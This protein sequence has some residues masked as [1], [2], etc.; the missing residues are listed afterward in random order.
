M[1]TELTAHYRRVKNCRGI[2]LL[3]APYF[4]Y[5]ATRLTLVEDPTCK[6]FWTDGTRIGYSPTYLDSVTDAE[7]RGV[8]VHEVLH[9]ALGHPWRRG[10]RDPDLW[11]VAADYALNPLVLAGGFTLPAGALLDDAYSGHNAE[12]IYDRLQAKQKKQ[13][14]PAG[15]GQGQPQPGQG[16][17]QPGQPGDQGKPDQ[18]GKP[19][20]G[21]AQKGSQPG[22]AAPGQANATPGVGEVRDAPPPAPATDQ[23]D[24]VAP[25][26]TESDWAEAVQI[27]QQVAKQQGKLPGGLRRE[28]KR[29]LR[30]PVDWRAVLLRWLQEQTAADYSWNHPNRRY[31]RFGYVLPSLHSVDC[32]RLAVFIDTSGSVDDVVLGQFGEQLSAVAAA[33]QPSALDVYYF[34]TAVYRRETFL[35]GEDV[36]LSRKVESGGT[37]F[38]PGFSAIEASEDGN[39]VAAIWL[40]D[41]HGTF[42]DVEPDYPVL[43]AVVGGAEH[44]PWGE[45]VPVE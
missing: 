21:D 39:P 25:D 6:T 11:N 4:G 23:A 22:Q 27:A 5:L 45:H 43:W 41:L 7:V 1:Q 2:V 9:C 13:Q 36:V 38:R 16:Q 40:T 42:P 34:H 35:R 44:N 28:L 29:A 31:A 18:A 26:L 32:G 37:D 20:P 14:P 33:V 8:L 10:L 12:W 15:Q 17:S 19:T 30:V 3:D 24:G